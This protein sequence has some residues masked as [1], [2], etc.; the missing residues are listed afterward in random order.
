MAGHSMIGE[1]VEYF[2]QRR[3]AL[4]LALRIGR[5]GRTPVMT[6]D[7][8][9]LRIGKGART[10]AM[11][12]DKP[13]LPPKVETNGQ[14]GTPEP[15]SMAPVSAL[16]LVA[17]SSSQIATAS[18]PVAYFFDTQKGIETMPLYST[19]VTRACKAQVPMTPNTALPPVAESASRYAQYA[20]YTTS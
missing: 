7:M 15:V 6:L 1:E 20:Q 11:T 5:D 18:E 2:K 17:E 19:K 8:P 13:A 10:P 12:L 16:T 9:A 14:P 4:A 3:R